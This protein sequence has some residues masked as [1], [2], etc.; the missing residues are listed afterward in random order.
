[1]C[2]TIEAVKVAETRD[3]HHYTTAEFLLDGVAV[4]EGGGDGTERIGHVG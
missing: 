3:S 1:M 2:W 4:G